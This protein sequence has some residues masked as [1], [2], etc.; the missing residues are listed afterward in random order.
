[1]YDSM[2]KEK[3]MMIWTSWTCRHFEWF[4]EIL[5]SLQAVLLVKRR[6]LNGY[7]NHGDMYIMLVVIKDKKKCMSIWR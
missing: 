1:M 3:A 6:A 4:S 2:F 5:L 7:I